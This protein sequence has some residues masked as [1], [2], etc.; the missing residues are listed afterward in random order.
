VTAVT[1][2]S[3][4]DKLA[5]SAYSKCK[6]VAR[7]NPRAADQRVECDRTYDV[8]RSRKNTPSTNSAELQLHS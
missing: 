7:D 4:A 1:F 6:H 3:Y 5:A 8:R 2:R